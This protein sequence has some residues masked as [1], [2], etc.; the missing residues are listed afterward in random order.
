VTVQPQ[1]FRA[2]TMPDAGQPLYSSRRYTLA[3][4]MLFSLLGKASVFCRRV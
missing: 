4:A 3:G 2:E 1:V